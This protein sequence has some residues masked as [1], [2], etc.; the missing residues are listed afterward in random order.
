MFGVLKQYL[1]C[2][3]PGLWIYTVS[4]V[5]GRD[6]KRP[7]VQGFQWVSDEIHALWKQ[8][9]WKKPKVPAPHKFRVR[10][11]EKEGQGYQQGLTDIS[12]PSHPDPG[13]LKKG[14]SQ[15]NC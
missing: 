15:G 13:R 8:K 2:V 10:K 4:E 5:D 11:R 3:L 7:R 14:Q 6:W 9:Y 1:A 12:S